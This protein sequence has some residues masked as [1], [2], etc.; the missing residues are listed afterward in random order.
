MTDGIKQLETWRGEF[1]KAYTDRNVMDWERRLPAFKNMLEGLHLERVLEVGCNRGHNLRALEEILGEDAAIFGVEPNAYARSIART[2]SDKVNPV[3]GNAY[4]LPFKDGYFDLVFT[5]G[6]LIHVPTEQLED[7]IKEIARA[8]RRYILAAEYFAEQD[9]VID[10]HGRNDLLWK[11]NFLE[12]Y[13]RNVPG[14]K[15]VRSG[16]WGPEDGFDRCTWWLM[17]KPVPNA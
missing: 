13:Q 7:A 17:E 11:R 6:V 3:P 5:V 15:L 16:Y 1:G 10:Y 9:T 12:H 2:I 4:D 8:T 14:L